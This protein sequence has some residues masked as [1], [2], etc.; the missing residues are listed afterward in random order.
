MLARTTVALTLAFGLFSSACDSGS[1]TFTVPLGDSSDEGS[2]DDVGAEDQPGPTV[3]EANGHLKVVGPQLQNEAGEAVQLKGVSSMWLNWEQ[4][5][6]AESLTALRW[7]RNNWNLKVIRAAM[8]VEP[9]GAYLSSPEIAKGQVFKIIDNAITA[10]VYVIVDWHDHAAHEHQDQAIAFFSEV[11]A[12]YAR[13]QPHLR[14]VQRTSR[15]RL[16]RL[17]ELPHGGRSCDPPARR[18]GT[19]RARNAQLLSGRR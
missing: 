2:N 12:K 17:E 5:G 1:S 6:F 11:A 14:D 18:G 9:D 3:V 19:D 8:G 15:R 13:S 10:G 4:D 7:L 16:A